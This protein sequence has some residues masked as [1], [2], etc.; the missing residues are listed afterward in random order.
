M[1]AIIAAIRPPGEWVLEARCTPDTADEWY[2][3]DGDFP[4]ALI[5][6]RVAEAKARCAGCP[7]KAE[8]LAYAVAT[9][10]VHGVWGGVDFSD[11]GERRPARREWK[12]PPTV[13][14]RC[15]TDKG[16]QAHYTRGEHP[17]GPCLAAR[18]DAQRLR[19]AQQQ[20]SA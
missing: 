8:C 12:R 7:V 2:R 10:Q 3:P 6:R 16:C 14:P 11:K 17:C 13:D 4:K 1:S 20:E 15:G 5:S 19:R 18:R 9:N